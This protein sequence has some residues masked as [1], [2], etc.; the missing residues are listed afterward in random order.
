MRNFDTALVSI[1]ILKTIT[2]NCCGEDIRMN[3]TEVLDDFVHIHKQWGYLSPYDGEN[4]NI[5]LCNNCYSNII[6]TFKIPPTIT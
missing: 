5:D 1:S 3:T 6:K 2:C 4:H